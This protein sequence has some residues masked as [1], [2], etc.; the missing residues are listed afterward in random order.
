MC[1]VSK[2]VFIDEPIE[3][4]PFR[5]NINSIFEKQGYPTLNCP[6]LFETSL[7]EWLC[8]PMTFA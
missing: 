5:L 4:F 3:L 1:D 6:L 7:P 8:K 2:Q